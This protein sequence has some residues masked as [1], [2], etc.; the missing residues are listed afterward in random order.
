MALSK[1]A[2]VYLIVSATVSACR[3]LDAPPTLRWAVGSGWLLMGGNGCF[4]GGSIKCTLAQGPVNWHGILMASDAIYR[5]IYTMYMWLETSFTIK[6]TGDGKIVHLKFYQKEIFYIFWIQYDLIAQ[7]ATK[8]IIFVISY[9]LSYFIN[10][11]NNFYKYENT[12]RF[13]R[14]YFSVYRSIL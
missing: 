11:N 14:Y 4:P 3:C 13:N 9:Q 1:P 2:N 5:L 7:Y 8:N 10:K 6:Q 12:F